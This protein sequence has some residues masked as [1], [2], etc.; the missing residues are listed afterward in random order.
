MVLVCSLGMF[1]IRAY[2]S[3]VKKMR[4]FFSFGILNFM[5]VMLYRI[6]SVCLHKPVTFPFRQISNSL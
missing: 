1:Y 2:F 3:F 5:K 6:S 4:V